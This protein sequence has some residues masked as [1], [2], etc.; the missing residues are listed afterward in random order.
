MGKYQTI[1][2]GDKAELTHT[3][4]QQDVEHFVELTG[5]DNRLHVDKSYAETTIFKK[6]VAHGMLGASF[7]STVIGTQL[8]GDGALW[9]AQSIEFLAPVRVGDTITV[10]A[11]VMK[12]YD[13]DHIIELQTDI[14]NQH[15][16]KVTAGIAKV[17]IIEPIEPP[18]VTTAQERRKV[19]LVIGATGG[20]GRAV[21]CQ[22]ALDGFSVA[23]HYYSNK[24]AA[25]E[26]KNEIES[27]AGTVIVCHA[28]IVDAEQVQ[29][30]MGEIARKLDGL[31]VV[32]NCATV[33][34]AFISFAALTWQ[35]IQ[36]HIDTNIKGVFHVTQSAVPLLEQQ[37]GGKI[38]NFTTQAIESPVNGWLPYITAK[39]ALQGFS[40]AL[41]VELAP[42]GITV[43]MISPGM[44]DT[45]LIADIPEKARLM[46]AARTPLRRI[47]SPTDIAGA[48]SFLASGHSDFMTGETIRINGGQVMI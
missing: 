39:S 43:N 44:T 28:D 23:I 3:I 34:L 15:K 38:I 45:E 29:K 7:I 1:S 30:M 20:I 2:V 24:Q 19:V 12:K 5:D 6:P 32:V 37:G 26:L 11:E 13:R 9:F 22:L 18:T 47:A 46:T 36:S 25:L 21:C 4:T 40:K 33:K 17:K 42:R 27:H 48:V 35:D 14:Y 8:P 31:T 10:Q 41:A 16:Q